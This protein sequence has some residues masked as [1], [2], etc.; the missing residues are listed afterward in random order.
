MNNVD[1]KAKT[2]LNLENIVKYRNKTRYYGIKIF[3]IEA[4]TQI[5]TFKRIS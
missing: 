2:A 1:F 5:Q 4:I 3:F